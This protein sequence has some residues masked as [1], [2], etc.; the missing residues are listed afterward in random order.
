MAACLQTCLKGCPSQTGAASV[1]G[2]SSLGGATGSLSQQINAL[3]SCYAFQRFCKGS[4]YF[5]CA[6][7]KQ[8]RGQCW[9]QAALR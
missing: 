6:A 2:L 1:V 4:S 8:A 7:G 9:V 3:T 5:S